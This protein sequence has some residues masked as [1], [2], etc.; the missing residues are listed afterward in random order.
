M[1][2]RTLLV[3]SLVACGGGDKKAAPDAKTADAARVCASPTAPTSANVDILNN[4]ASAAQNPFIIWGGPGGDAGDGN[5]LTLQFEFYKGIES[6]LMGT[7]D[8]SM[9]NQTNYMTC[10]VCLHAYSLDSSGNPIKEFFQSGGSVTLT[11]DPFTNQHMIASFSNVT[12]QE[13]TIDQNTFASTPVAGGLCASYGNFSVDHDK[14]PNAY[15]CAKNTYAD[16]TT[17]NC[18]CGGGSGSAAA[19][20]EDPDC[21]NG[22]ATVNGCTANQI[23]YF[24]DTCE[25]APLNDKCAA[26][27]PIVIGTPVTGTTVNAANNYDK[28]LEGSTCDGATQPGPD[29]AYSVALTA[30]Q[31]ITVTLSGLDATYDGSVA[32]VGPGT[33]ATACDANPITLCVKGADTAGAGANETF[34]YTATTAGTYYLIVDSF[35]ADQAGAFTL[36]V[37]SP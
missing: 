32:L 19:T 14:V 5:Q 3:L 20:A 33:A 37:T 35:F 36:N 2:A 7:F 16:G 28:G 29:V 9:G 15:T 12:M 8:L 4:G 11:E 22:N 17:C 25:T 31:A 23:C 10:A 1:R 24:N 13:V 34:Q 30:N 6:S 26:A 18:G 21:A 27:T